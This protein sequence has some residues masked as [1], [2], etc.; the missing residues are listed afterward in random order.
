[1]TTAS[2]VGALQ[3]HRFERPAG[4]PMMVR[5]AALDA[6]Y[7][8]AGGIFWD[9]D[10]PAK[11]SVERYGGAAIIR[12]TGP[13]T[14][15]DEGWF[16][17]YDAIG[18]RL[19]AAIASSPRPT[20]IVMVLDTP[21]GDASGCFE[22]AASMRQRCAE[23]RVPLV[24]FVEGMACS[25]GYALACAA[26]RIVA[27]PSSIVGSIGVVTGV[28]DMSGALAMQGVKVR[29]IKSGA[30]KT[31]GSPYEPTSRE[32]EAS[33][34][35]LIDGLAGLF[36]NHV[37]GSR[38]GAGG[39]A[40]VAALEAECF[41]A[42][43]GIS[44]GL[45]DEVGT[46]DTAVAIPRMTV[47]ALAAPSPTPASALTEANRRASAQSRKTTT[48]PT[49]TTPR[50]AEGDDT[51]PETVST[52]EEG[53]FAGLRA[54]MEM[55][56]QPAQEVLDAAAERISGVAPADAAP[57]DSA[58]RAEGLSAANHQLRA[59]IATMSANYALLKPMADAHAK[60]VRVAAIDFELAK[61]GMS[62]AAREAYLAIAD[63]RGLDA[64]IESIDA[65]HVPPTGGRVGGPPPASST[66]AGDPT[67]APTSSMTSGEAVAAEH[68]AL[69]AEGKIT[70]PALYSAALAGARK[71]H[72]GAFSNTH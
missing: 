27:T 52:M 62:G 36:F 40:G 2:Q 49:Q 39:V 59:D 31:D 5:E 11:P 50:A 26:H 13:L 63:K 67:S 54:A 28:V 12:V 38:P 16:E 7:P 46:L 6:H 30:R 37:A 42:G 25:A 20:S 64:A 55:P 69:R 3:R 1:M 10:E 48:V 4:S 44:A 51:M 8:R 71:K 65:A 23:A 22:L 9:D 14:H 19:A 53:D 57:D 58:K 45:V 34:Q 41:L 24:A 15:H 43:A 56:D 47:A 35:G 68:T 66:G 61:R 32:A 29:L 33:I 70:G 21:G 72:P 17:S 60:S 18:Q